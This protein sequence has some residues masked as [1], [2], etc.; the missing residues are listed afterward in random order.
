MPYEKNDLDARI[1]KAIEQF[2]GVPT[3]RGLGRG[4]GVSWDAVARRIETSPQLVEAME[5]RGKEWLEGLDEKRFLETYSNHGWTNS[6]PEYAKQIVQQRFDRTIMERIEGFDG[7]PTAKELGEETGVMG[8]TIARRMKAN[9]QLFEAMEKQ[10]REWLGG[11]DEKRFLETYS[12]LGWMGPM[13]VY[14]KQIAQQ[15]F[16]KI[17]IERIERFDGVPNAK[18]L[19]DEIG[20]S[21][22]VITRKIE[23]S[24]Q[25]V[26][27]M[28]KRGREWLEG[29]D[30]KRF[31]ETY[32]ER[33]LTGALPE[34][35]KQIVWQKLDR[36]IL[37][38]IEGFDGVPTAKGLG[39]KT[40]MSTGAVARRIE[41]SP[42]LVEAM[43]KRG[44]EW[45]EGLDEK[46]FL[47]MYSNKSGAANMP[48]YAKQIL[49]QRFD[50]IILEKIE[51]FDG[52]PTAKGL[53]RKTRVGPHSV[54]KRIEANPQLA[55]AMEKR[56]R[57]WLEGLDEKRFLEMY[58]NWSGSMPNYAKQ[59]VQQRFDRTIMERIEGFDG[60]PT[61][62]GLG[63]DMGVS[64]PPVARRIEANK[65]IW[66]VYY[67]K[68]GLTA[69]QAVE[70]A[71][72]HNDKSEAFRSA[73]NERLRHLS[74]FRE[75][76]GLLR[77]FGELLEKDTTV[78]SLYPEPL[79]QAADEL[80]IN[81]KSN[82][83]DMG[84]FRKGETPEIPGCG[85]IVF[86]GLHRLKE[87]ALSAVFAKI[88]ELHSEHPALS[89]ITT[90]G[91]DYS[92]TEGFFEALNT[93][94]LEM[95][96]SGVVRI[97][98]PDEETLLSYGV[99]EEDLS[100][101]GRKISCEFNAM[102][103]GF[104]GN[105]GFVGIPALEKN[106]KGDGRPLT[107][108]EAE[109]VDVPKGIA[110]ELEAKLF[111]ACVVVP[112]A[113]LM[114][115]ICEKS[116]I[117]A[118]VGFDMDPDRK[119]SLEVVPYPNAPSHDYRRI[120]RKIASDVGFRSKQGIKTGGESRI[121]LS[122]CSGS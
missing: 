96:E 71:L 33:G 103:F 115:E 2:D 36:I 67:M 45:L 78:V 101:L 63:M 57:E 102:V 31:L 8:Q 39:R 109:G 120:A 108:P 35:A 91:I 60:V 10:G 58:S 65:D 42:Q 94:G 25:L 44:R 3:T 56:G 99:A 43:E 14:A 81:V 95:K 64:E 106:P 68:R 75:M 82:H 21:G 92:V 5:K 88:E 74:A 62:K 12:N 73:L 116:N 84:L 90:H 66:M 30:E 79:K 41:T 85:T 61:A 89:I 46:R 37:E 118:L 22:Q 23:T 55:E 40:S 16:D 28:E 87:E 32:S 15:R 6:M 38:K 119:K 122:G 27:A 105:D 29:L 72:E 98:P 11:L 51:G 50:R 53:G 86:Q 4:V 114:V 77:C 104:N 121:Q 112:S 110:K 34:Y 47:E 26:K 54:A 20:V 113:P 76:V 1:L 97:S 49:Q 18:R 13:P 19:G 17:I 117:V 111:P 80:G 100:R 83:V 48:E 9:P 24:Q 69:D 7:V 107:L 93:N 52:V 70:L 59:I